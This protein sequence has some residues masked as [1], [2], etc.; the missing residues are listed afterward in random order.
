[1]YW[2]PSKYLFIKNNL[3]FLISFNYSVDWW[4]IHHSTHHA[5]PNVINKD[6]D[7][8]SFTGIHSKTGDSKWNNFFVLGKIL[9]K[10]VIIF[11]YFLIQFH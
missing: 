5:K 4:N 6:S 1:M 3:C 2:E 10:E 9:P 8:V 7:V 11:E